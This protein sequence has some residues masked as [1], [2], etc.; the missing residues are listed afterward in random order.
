MWK[1]VSLQ[2]WKLLNSTHDI[3][4]VCRRE[5]CGWDKTSKNPSARRIQCCWTTKKKISFS[6]ALSQLLLAVVDVCRQ[7][8]CCV[9]DCA[10]RRDGCD[11]VHFA[12]RCTSHPA[13]DPRREFRLA[14]AQ[15]LCCSKIDSRQP[16]RVDGAADRVEIVDGAS[17]MGL[18]AQKTETMRHSSKT[19]FLV[20]RR[21]PLADSAG[22]AKLYVF[23]EI[24]W[25]NAIFIK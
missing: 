6:L 23:A 13:C 16:T 7:R 18:S 5:C 15:P 3:C 25:W 9:C 1:M 21:F 22:R 17:M 11:K 19:F 8:L 24:K 12:T 20:V 14:I 4:Y 2:I 10:P